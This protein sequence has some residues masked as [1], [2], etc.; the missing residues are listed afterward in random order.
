M[1]ENDLSK[2]RIEK[3][4]ISSHRRRKKR[5]GLLIFLLVVLIG[6]G[7]LY[8]KGVLTPAV[9]VQTAVVQNIYPSQ[10]FTL[11]NASGYV[12][13]QRKAALASKITSRLVFLAVEEGARVKAGDV[14]ARLE[15]D[16][17]IAARDRVKA[18][19]EASRFALDQAKADLDNAS[20]IYNR[21][22]VLLA[23]RTVTHAE[24]DNAL[25][26]YRIAKAVVNTQQAALRAN[27]AALREAEVSLGYS[28]IKSPFD[29]VVLTK[30]ADVGDIVTPLGAA[31]NAKAS[32]VTI[33]DMDSLQV[34]ADVSESNI[35]QVKIGQPCELRLDAL[36]DARLSGKVH[37]IVPT[38]DRSKASVMVKIAFID[39]HPKI[40]PEMGAKVAFL[41]REVLPEETKFVKTLLSS[42]IV[43]RNKEHFV[44]VV[45]NNL[46]MQRTIRINRQMGSMSEVLDGID[47]GERI[48]IS[49]LNKMTDRIKVKISE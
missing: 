7:V 4:K 22:N 48:V 19:V 47:A 28:E 32:V 8:K 46:A 3:P 49:P 5:Y 2:L 27:E 20:I 31:A 10:T 14:I 41:S 1:P 25:A 15:N 17:T 24:Y 38:A 39:K 36:P 40:L 34:E 21:S 13:A 16:D 6:A 23:Q 43:T 35:G 12:V 30:N 42:A 37:T 11:L 18:N 33:A 29:G 26:K 45:K 9:E 44:F